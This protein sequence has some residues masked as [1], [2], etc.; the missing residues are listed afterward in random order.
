MNKRSSGVTLIELMISIG[1]FSITLMFAMPSLSDFTTRNRVTTKINTIAIAIR[2]ARESAVNFNAVSTLCRSNGQQHCQ[3]KWHEGMVVFLDYNKD[4]ILDDD[5]KL[6]TLFEKFPEGDTIFWRAFQN[7]QYLQMSPLGYTR[8]QNGTFTYCPK[9]G[10]KYA[11]GIIINRAGS[12]RFTT[13]KN[14]DGIDE[15]ANGKPLRC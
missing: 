8:Y 7:R 11:R 1:I 2:L 10:L 3:G 15:G 5:D 6:I 12:I 14:N 9:E 13:D 4:H